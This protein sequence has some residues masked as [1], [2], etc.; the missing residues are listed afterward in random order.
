[1]TLTQSGLTHKNPTIHMYWNLRRIKGRQFK[2]ASDNRKVKTA[3]YI[4]HHNI[5][6]EPIS[7]QWYCSHANMDVP[8]AVHSKSCIILTFFF[9]VKLVLLGKERY[10]QLLETIQSHVQ[11][12]VMTLL[13]RK[14]DCKVEIA[15]KCKYFQ[16]DRG[17]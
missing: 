11:A 9:L 12:I 16:L 10:Y 13:S 6:S 7:L 15:Q 3:I 8:G 5:K 2:L 1:M 4:S 14:Q 17:T